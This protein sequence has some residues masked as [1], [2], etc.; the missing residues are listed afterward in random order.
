M[1]LFQSAL[2]KIDRGRLGL[3]VGIPHGLSKLTD[4]VPN[5][6]QGT[7]YL[8]GAGTGVGKTSF[9]DDIFLYNTYDFI[10]KNKTDITLDIDYFS[11]EIEK[12]LKITKGIC[13]KL[14][15]DFRISID[16][17]YALSRGKN[18]MSDEVY[19]KVIETKEY[20]DQLDD[21]I[22][23]FDMPLNPTAIYRYLW[24]KVEKNGKIIK[25]VIDTVDQAG[26]PIKMEIF[27]KYIPNDPQKY[28]FVII[29]HI[30]L[31]KTESGLTLKDTIDKISSHLVFFRN[32]FN[33]IPVVIQ[34]LNYD[35][36][37]PLRAKLGRLSPMLSDFGDSKYTTRDANY[38]FSLFSPMSL[39]MTHFPNAEGYDIT[40]LRD[41]FRSMEILKGRDG[42]IGTR[43][44]LLFHGKVGRFWELPSPEHMG[45]DM[46]G[47]I[48]TL[49]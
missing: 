31:S 38:V 1:S 14:F 15:E 49:K 3:N 16:L 8:I 43:V 37:D 39:N 47:N 18:K 17:N 44:G 21:V 48:E 28:H 41:K 20:F 6:Q 33:I 2:D 36:T 46:Y 35:I 32:N 9:V 42:G 11:F 10:K 13:R 7:Y 5:I 30:S 34:Q 12:S 24:N 23:I 40:R 45:A 27:D 25:K 4:Y 19:A 29:D 26:N 22:N